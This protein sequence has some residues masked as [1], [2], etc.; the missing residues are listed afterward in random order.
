LSGTSGSSGL[1]GSS[2]TSPN[3]NLEQTLALGNNVGTYSIIG[4]DK[5]E[6]SVGASSS[7][8][9]QGV[10]INNV[11]AGLRAGGVPGGPWYG[12]SISVQPT[13]FILRSTGTGSANPSTIQGAPGVVSL[14]TD[15]IQVLLDD[16]NGNL[17]LAAGNRVISLNQTGIYAT[18][19]S[20][21]GNNFITIDD[22][23]YLGS[24][25]SLASGTSGTS[26]QSGTSGTSG[27][28]G[29]NG[30]DGSSG[31]SGQSGSSGNSGV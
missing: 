28:S 17:A 30:L 5:L 2:G 12:S 27:V 29:N 22:N 7:Y 14:E 15:D 8:F 3:Q 20:G 13:Y 21:L 19:F 6:L 1:S 31:T 23:G 4:S 16:N 10:Q 9:G 18:G 24:T 11:G 26:G 25:S